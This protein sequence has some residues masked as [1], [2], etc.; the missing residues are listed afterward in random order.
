MQFK[1]KTSA[2]FSKNH[3]FEQITNNNF[4]IFSFSMMSHSFLSRFHML[5][6][7]TAIKKKY[8]YLIEQIADTDWPNHIENVANNWNIVKREIE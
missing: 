5:K 7:L 4:P 1:I 8:I 2:C 6:S 3:I